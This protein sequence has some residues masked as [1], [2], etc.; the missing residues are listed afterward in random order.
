MLRLRIFVSWMQGW[1]AIGNVE[2]FRI[3]C[4]VRRITASRLQLAH[5]RNRNGK[6]GPYD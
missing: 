6:D 5:Y 3:P 1:F 4:S 2:D